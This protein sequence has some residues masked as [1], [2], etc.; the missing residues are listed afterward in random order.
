MSA[1]FEAGKQENRK[2]TKPRTCSICG[3]FLPR[4]CFFPMHFECAFGASAQRSP[5]AE[6]EKDRRAA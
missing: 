5:H 6:T 2:G 1:K 4:L 3:K